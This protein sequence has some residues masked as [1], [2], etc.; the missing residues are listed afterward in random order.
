MK[1]WK[2]TTSRGQAGE[3]PGVM[4]LLPPPDQEAVDTAEKLRRHF[5]RV[6]TL[7]QKKHLRMRQNMI[8]ATIT[9]VKSWDFETYIS[10]EKEVRLNI[11][12]ALNDDAEKVIQEGE[13]NDP[14]LRRLEREIAEVNKL[15]DEWE[16]RALLEDEKRNA[17]KKFMEA[18]DSLEMT[19]TEYEKSI[20]KVAKLLFQEMLRA[21]R[22]WSSLTRSLSPT[23]KL[24]N[25]W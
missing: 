21:C 19:L 1:A 11:R 3:A 20:I 5:D 24:K 9:V 25:L 14:Q 12:K 13:P 2:F 7:W 16:R 18:I 10:M 17:L 23:F 6:I 22:P 4:F 15:F 8:F